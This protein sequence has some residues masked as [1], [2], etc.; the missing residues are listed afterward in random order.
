MGDGLQ[1]FHTDLSRVW[2][3]SMPACHTRSACQADIALA[4]EMS[5]GMVVPLCH[6]R[7][8]SHRF[9]SHTPAVPKRRATEN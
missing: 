2:Q 8:C 5:A 7:R 6:C 1:P 9:L 4:D 3:A